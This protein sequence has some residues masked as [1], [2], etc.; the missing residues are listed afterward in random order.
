MLSI[1]PLKVEAE[2][3]V[4]EGV[5]SVRNLNLNLELNLKQLGCL[6]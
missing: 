1:S 3:K 5:N 6:V 4:K 2:V